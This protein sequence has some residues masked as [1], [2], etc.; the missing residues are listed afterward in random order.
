MR[1]TGSVLW[2]SPI[3]PQLQE[4]NEAI[5]FSPTCHIPCCPHHSA[6]PSA[7]SSSSRACRW[8]PGRGSCRCG[9]GTASSGCQIRCRRRTAC[10]KRLSQVCNPIFVDMLLY[11][12][13]CATG[14]AC[15]L[16]K[17]VKLRVLLAMKEMIWQYYVLATSLLGCSIY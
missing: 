10:P 3:K 8:S 17:I 15:E 2:R 6:R 14:L 7:P 4:T 9:G 11:W 1:P 16:G 12:L 13:L 5:R